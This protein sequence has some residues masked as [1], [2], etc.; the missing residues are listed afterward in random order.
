MKIKVYTVIIIILIASVNFSQ[1][2]NNYGIKGGFN[3]SGISS[4]ATNTVFKEESIRMNCFNFDLG[5]FKEWFSTKRFCLSTELHYAVKGEITG[6]AY[7]DI[8]PTMKKIFYVYTTWFFPDRFQYL[9]FQL[10][11]KYRTGFTVPPAV[12]NLYLEGGIGLNTMVGNYNSDIDTNIV[13]LKNFD[14]EVSGILGMGIEIAHFIDIEF[15]YEHTF[16]GPYTATFGNTEIYRN[17]N[18]FIFL[19]GISINYFFEKHSKKHHWDL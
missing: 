2:R 1:V 3:F 12:D 19:T 11:P 18:S 6:N 7:V 15:R 16:N 14:C 4:S 5:I 10:L 17:L 8:I 9:S 13:H